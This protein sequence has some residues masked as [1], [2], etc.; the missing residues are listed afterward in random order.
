MDYP[1]KSIVQDWPEEG[2]FL[3]PHFAEGGRTLCSV[4][5]YGRGARAAQ[6]FDIE[7][8]NKIAEFSGFKGGIPGAVSTKGSRIVLTRIRFFPS[9]DGESDMRSYKDRI[10][11]DFRSDKQVAEWVPRTQSFEAPGWRQDGEQ[12]WG[13]NAISPA[14]HYLAEGANGVLR[15]YELP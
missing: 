7:S 5:S 10:V 6:C 15:I 11:W 8:G 12:R 13:P 3:E 14:G 4:G 1:T 2:P 9:L